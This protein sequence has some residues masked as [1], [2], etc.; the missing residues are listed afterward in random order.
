MQN[1]TTW[2]ELGI[3]LYDALTGRGAEITYEFDGMEID[4]PSR[5]GDDAS[6]AKWRLNGALRIRCQDNAVNRG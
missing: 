5:A 1:T 4:V 2:P 6:H 3:G